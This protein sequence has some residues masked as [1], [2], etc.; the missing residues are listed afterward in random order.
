[1]VLGEALRQTGGFHSG[2]RASD[3]ASDGASDQAG[4]ADEGAD[5]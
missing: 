2:D 4:K 1:M 5:R 3:G